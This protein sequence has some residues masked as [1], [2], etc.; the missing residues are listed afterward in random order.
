MEH[1]GYHYEFRRT[2]GIYFRFWQG[3]RNAI[4]GIYP[5]PDHVPTVYCHAEKRKSSRGQSM[6]LAVA[7]WI[8]TLAPLG[9]V[10][11][12]MEPAVSNR[13]LSFWESSVPYTI[14]CTSI[15]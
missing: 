5:K 13:L 12:I 8:G 6:L 3:K 4:L 14:Y 11:M 1:S 10:C 15:S 7:K 9:I 2:M